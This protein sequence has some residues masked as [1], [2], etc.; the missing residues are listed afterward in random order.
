M[1]SWAP[2]EPSQKKILIHI[3][4]PGRCIAQ[5]NVVPGSPI[6]ELRSVLRSDRITFLFNGILL[7]DSNSF[8]F[9]GIREQD[10]LLALPIPPEA[11][12]TSGWI[13]L[14]QDT[15]SFKER[16]ECLLNRGTASE[17]ARIR[18]Q[19]FTKIE[20]RPR[21][22]RRLTASCQGGLEFPPPETQ[23]SAMVIARSDDAPSVAPLPILWSEPAANVM[24]APGQN[25]GLVKDDQFVSDREAETV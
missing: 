25:L 9:Y 18:D 4:L 1:K 14:S 19:Q 8:D 6:R 22:F 15:E 16:L 11:A 7:S 24:V 12:Y 10:F 2:S 20:R 13:S 3:Y 17:V 23:S 5:V 21:T